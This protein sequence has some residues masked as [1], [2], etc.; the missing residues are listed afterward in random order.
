MYAF[1]DLLGAALPELPE[2]T[3]ARR[4]NFCVEV[5]VESLASFES[6]IRQVLAV[7]ARYLEPLVESV[8][9]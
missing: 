7:R 6:E 1:G 9:D 5:A 8:A 2:A 3:K 4:M